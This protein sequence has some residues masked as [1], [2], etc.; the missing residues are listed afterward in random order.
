LA[1]AGGIGVANRVLQN[2]AERIRSPILKLTM[3][4]HYPSRVDLWLKVVLLGAPVGVVVLGVYLL[5]QSVGAGVI[6]IITGLGVGGLTALLALPC[7]YT[8]TDERLIIRC[9]LLTDEVPLR[10]IKQ[11]E[12][13][14]SL[15]S[16]PA[17]SLQRIKLTLDDGS[18]VISPLDRDQFL[19][20]LKARGAATQ[21]S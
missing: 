16:A 5:T 21:G 10:R 14:S 17:L 1:I 13:S 9:G 6:T 18:R 8:L 3:S 20:D 2:V 4:T 19:T 15:W 7:H 11:A 12:K